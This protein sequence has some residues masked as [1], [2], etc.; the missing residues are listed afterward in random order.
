MLHW[1][2]FLIWLLYEKEGVIYKEKELDLNN[3]MSL[4]IS[5]IPARSRFP[6]ESI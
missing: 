3:D 4:D 5:S 6:I 2:Y 1:G